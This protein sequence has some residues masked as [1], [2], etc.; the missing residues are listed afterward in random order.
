MLKP[1][2]RE[3]I[4]FIQWWDLHFP[5]K[6]CFHIPNEGSRARAY[7]KK[8]QSMGLRKGV[9]D[10]LIVP[11][12]TFIEFKCP[13]AKETQPPLPPHQEECRQCYSQNMLSVVMYSADDTISFVKECF[14]VKTLDERRAIAQKY[15]QPA[16]YD[17]HKKLAYEAVKKKYPHWKWQRGAI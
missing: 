6:L 17:Y 1:E 7:G 14:R 8:L 11:L 2:E 12:E 10:I 3:Q 13:K 4:K 5:P 15:E 16:A 9:P